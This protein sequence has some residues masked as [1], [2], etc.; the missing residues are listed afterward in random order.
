MLSMMDLKNKKIEV[1]KRRFYDKEEVDEYLEFI[2]E[3]YQELYKENQEL[4]KNVKTLSDGIQYYRSIETT[5]QKALVLAEK[6]AKETKDAAQLKAEAMEK[7]AL[8]KAEQI[9]NQAEQEYDK[10]KDKCLN[11][12]SQ[13]NQ[14]KIQLQ[15][16]ATA[17]LEMITSDTFDVYSPEIEA[18]REEKQVFPEFEEAGEQ[19]ETT[20]HYSIPAEEEMSET[21]ATEEMADTIPAQQIESEHFDKTMQIPDVKAELKEKHNNTNIGQNLDDVLNADTIDL[22]DTL[23]EVQ[24]PH[25]R[26]PKNVQ[27][28]LVLEPVDAVVSEP[29]NL[30]PISSEPAHQEVLEPNEEETKETPT[31]DSLL[32][33]INLGNNKK[34]KKK[35]GQDED[36]FEF[37]GSVDDF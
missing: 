23:K 32:Q 18:I 5:M 8:S 3:N 1:K 2:F 10:I 24:K 16:V 12:V 26:A 33:S 36:P 37:L 35:K 22:S 27:D 14:Y 13:F 31:L 11:L 7:D 34:N 17:Q 15:Q 28:A 19:V 25:N 6:T 21:L 20:Q 30:E 9:V 4:T 29:I